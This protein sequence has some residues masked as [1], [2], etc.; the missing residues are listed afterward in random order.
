LSAEDVGPAGKERLAEP[1]E[2]LGRYPAGFTLDT[3]L[4]LMS[5]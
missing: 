3:Y 2:R 1:A 4:R 5:R